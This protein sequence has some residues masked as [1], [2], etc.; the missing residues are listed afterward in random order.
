[1][2][3]AHCLCE[4]NKKKQIMIYLYY[5]SDIA[6]GKSSMGVYLCSIVYFTQDDYSSVWCLYI[7]RH[8]D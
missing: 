8:R 6:M 2:C 7:I 1:M 3:S 5:L 4:S